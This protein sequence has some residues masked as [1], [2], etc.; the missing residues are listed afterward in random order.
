MERGAT[1]LYVLS[2]DLFVPLRGKGI[3]KQMRV[4]FLLLQTASYCGMLLFD[5]SQLFIFRGED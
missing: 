1:G 4:L 3:D 5:A 2:L